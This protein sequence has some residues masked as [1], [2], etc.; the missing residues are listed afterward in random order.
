ME[1]VFLP[2]IR[3]GRKVR[4]FGLLIGACG[5]LLSAHLATAQVPRGVFSLSGAGA[6]CRTVVLDNP[7]VDGVSIRQ[8]WQDLE[9]TEGVYN[10]TFLDAE[11]ARIAASGKKILLRINTQAH[12]PA[13]VNSA[14]VAAGGDFFTFD[15]DG[16]QTTIPVFWD[17][18]FLAKKKAMITALG[19]RFTSN[20]A[21]VM[22]W[23]SFANANSE[24]WSVPHTS[25]DI[26]DW[27]ALGYTSEKM[28]DAGRQIID[29]TMQAFPNQYITLA[30]G[31]SGHAGATGNL[32][33]DE[34][35]VARNVVLA[36]EATWPGRLIVQK[37]NVAAFI[38]QAPGADTLY[39]LLWDSRPNV[40][41]QMLDDCFGE[42]TFRNNGGVTADAATIL[43]NSI[44]RGFGYG[45]NF[46]EIYQDDVLNLPSEIVFAHN[47][48]LGYAP[49]N[50]AALPLN[51]PT[52]PGGV[53]AQE[54]P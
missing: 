52:A 13:W 21:I 18:T 15:N 33:P 5:M 49:P 20:P 4:K 41:G 19:A 23:S 54:E 35:Y 6:A 14:V 29:T 39:Q 17:P 40:G 46:I 27:F 7:N 22:V 37:N 11:V 44:S 50:E 8:D 51:A 25:H 45:M 9:P 16:V 1:E 32:D 10:W 2:P 28:I 42:T 3:G 34:S 30:V 53:Q 43:R 48:L 36:A 26:A 31:G 47:L 38:P 12:K 24:D